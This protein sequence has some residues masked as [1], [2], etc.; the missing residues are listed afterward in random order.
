MAKDTK[1]GATKAQRESQATASLD[2][3]ADTIYKHLKS[4]SV[5][6]VQLSSRN[7]S[8]IV[9]DSKSG[10]W[11]Y[12]TELTTRSAKSLDGAYMLLRT[13]FLT[14]FI[15]QM[16]GENKSSTLREMYYISEGWD[17]AKFHSQ[18]ES[19]LLAEDLEV[20]TGSMREDFKLRPEENGAAMMGDLSIVETRAKGEDLRTHPPAQRAPPPLQVKGG[21][22]R[23][24]VGLREGRLLPPPGRERL[25]HQA[26]LHTR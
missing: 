18:D 7:K 2:G 6:E 5:P 25:R 13:M 23:L 8:N 9:L 26:Q 14:D 1:R 3:I 15:K 24:G 21:Q 12:G 16:I 20:M 19:D 17:L 22:A 10:V 11:R 4:A